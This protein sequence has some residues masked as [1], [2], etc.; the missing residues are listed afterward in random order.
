MYG[1]KWLEVPCVAVNKGGLTLNPKFLELYCKGKC[2]AYICKDEER[3][4]IGI[5]LVN[6]EESDDGAYRLS[7][8]NKSRGSTRVL[9]CK[10]IAEERPD[11]IGKAFRAIRNANGS[12]IEI[13]LSAEN[14]GRMV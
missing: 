8:T 2:A 10:Y 6:E 5:K 3:N 7:G 13:E 12:L 1:P 9:V 11:C 14:A 4:L